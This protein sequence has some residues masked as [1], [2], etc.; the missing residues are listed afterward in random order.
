MRETA[1]NP[2]SVDLSELDAYMSGIGAYKAQRGALTPDHII[3]LP[4]QNNTLGYN[5]GDDG[6]DPAGAFALSFP[7]RPGIAA[8]SR[9]VTAGLSARPQDLY[10]PYYDPRVLPGAQNTPQAATDLLKSL[11]FQGPASGA[12]YDTNQPIMTL[13]GDP[14]KPYNRQYGDVT[15]TLPDLSGERNSSE[16][17]RALSASSG[18]DSETR[19]IISDAVLKTGQ[20]YSVSKARLPAEGT[21]PKVTEASLLTGSMANAAQ[22]AS[23]TLDALAQNATKAFTSLTDIVKSGTESGNKRKNTGN[24]SSL[25]DPQEKQGKTEPSVKKTLKTVSGKNQITLGQTGD[26]SLKAG[27]IPAP[28]SSKQG[29]K[30]AQNIKGKDGIRLTSDEELRAA[31]E[32]IIHNDRLFSPNAKHS[33][34]GVDI[35]YMLGAIAMQESHGDAKAISKA[36]AQGLMQLMSGTAKD[37]GVTNRLDPVQSWEAAKKYVTHYLHLYHGDPDRVEKTLAAYN[38]GPGNLRKDIR[39]NG[40]NWRDGLAKPETRDYIN[41]FARNVTTGNVIR[42]ENYTGQS[43][44]TSSRRAAIK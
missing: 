6:A 33:V 41:K 26:T 30:K 36:G 10:S 17:T 28:T 14:Q 7:G 2:T 37:L 4:L 23:D 20:D 42:I 40:V 31:H 38:W 34:E 29:Q 22:K 8:G 13:S 44:T 11:N 39:Q 19:H 24:H 35:D 3:T 1:Q 25:K 12:V 9:L 27:S 15:G 21:A 32:A 18:K 43:L 5:M 16:E